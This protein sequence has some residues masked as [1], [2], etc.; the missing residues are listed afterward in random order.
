MRGSPKVIELL[1]TDLL[2]NQ[3]TQKFFVTA[4]ELKKQVLDSALFVHLIVNSRENSSSWML[5]QPSLLRTTKMNDEV[6]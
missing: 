5:T 6:E 2:K 4:H 3:Q 1:A